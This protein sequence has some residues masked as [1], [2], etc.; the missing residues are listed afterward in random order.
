M[1]KEPLGSLPAE[2]LDLS[3]PCRPLQLRCGCKGCLELPRCEL[4]LPP[5]RHLLS[6]FT[7]P[8]LLCSLTPPYCQQA[9][10]W[11]YPLPPRS[12]QLSHSCFPS[13]FPD[14]PV[15]RGWSCGE[16]L[17]STVSRD[18]ATETD[19]RRRLR[20]LL[21]QAAVNVCSPALAAPTQCSVEHANAIPQ[22]GPEYVTAPSPRPFFSHAVPGKEPSPLLPLHQACG[23][24]PQAYGPL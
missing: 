20:P 12:L 13:C 22:H 4:A 6:L 5:A 9:P 23:W 16:R 3:S 2:R 7:P 18:R 14:A 17:D 19:L 11:H 15:F 1:E 10:A 24:C 21:S 8:S